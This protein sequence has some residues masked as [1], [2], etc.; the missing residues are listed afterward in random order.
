VFRGR[1][2]LTGGLILLETVTAIQLLIV[3]TVMPVV[4]KELGGLRLYG[5]A[6]AAAGI[7]AIVALPAT[8]QWADR[9][10]P[11]RALSVVMTIFVA[12]TVLASLAPSM[13]VFVVGRFLQ[14]WGLGA[15]YAVSLGAVA[16]TYPDEYRPRVLALL[17]AA[18]VI[19]SLIGPSLGAVI[20][21]TAGWRWAFAVSLPF[22]AV[23]MWLVLPE[24]RR[25]PS[26]PAG[27]VDRVAVRWLV[28]LA[29]GTT[30]LLWGLTELTWWSIAL[31]V[32]GALLLLPALR[33][34]LPRGTFRARRGLP[35]AAAASFLVAF[36]F[37]GMD[38]FIPLM[39]TDVRGRTVAAAGLVIT[40]ASVAWAV[41]SW[42]Q[43]RVAG[44]R[45][46][47]GLV[48]G[49][50][51]MVLAGSAAMA[52]GLATGVPLAL[53]FLGWTLA[54]FGMGVAYPTI[55]LVSM[56][57]AIEG[58]QTQSIASVQ[59]SEALGAALGP[60]LGGCAV[61]LAASAGASLTTGL[62][63]AFALCLA[64]GILLLA[65]CRRLPSPERAA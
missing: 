25:L 53:P 13:P 5:W 60:G 21:T 17:S 15:Q 1:G 4:V 34:I 40:L 30:A 18:W 48:A 2:R 22:V 50:D 23:A 46:R 14:G 44:R 9:W 57:Q 24:L 49:G 64:A 47:S 52:A 10:G 36:A 3:I 56:E 32:G 39:V 8:G 29:A 45:T 12:G 35:A 63:G 28:Q 43:S 31:V 37:F 61:A 27:A 59:L 26:T 38:G 7:A 33:R 41:G 58:R 62:A 42:W 11:A 51:A 65:V 20:A 19:P 55:T 6:F 16:K 54:G